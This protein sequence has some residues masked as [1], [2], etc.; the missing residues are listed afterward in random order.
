MPTRD[1]LGGIV[2]SYQ[3]YDP[4]RIPPPRPPETDLVSPVMEHLLEFGDID[5]LTPEELAGAVILDPEQI[6]GLGPSL[7]SLKRILEERRRR[8]LERYDASGLAGR[9][10]GAFGPPG[11]AEGG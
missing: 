10:R 2:H 11:A 5:E 7:E 1:D 3:K 8:I 4:V 6:R 9:A